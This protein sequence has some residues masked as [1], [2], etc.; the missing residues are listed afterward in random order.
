MRLVRPVGVE[1]LLRRPLT[2]EKVPVGASGFKSLAFNAYGWAFLVPGQ[3]G[4]EP[5]W[6]KAVL[7]IK[8]FEAPE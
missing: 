5:L 6:A 8:I 4:V 1:V 2:G 7:N 3:A